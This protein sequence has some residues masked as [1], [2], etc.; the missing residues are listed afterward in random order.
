MKK[1]KNQI[2]VSLEEKEILLREL[3]H[4]TKNN[5][6]VIISMLNLQTY[7]ISDKKTLEIFKETE[8]RIR[9][10]AMVH[11]KLY[12]GK[13]LSRIDMK[14]YINDLVSLLMRS[15]PAMLGRIAF[16]LDMESVSITIDSAVPCGLIINE[17]FSNAMKHAFPGDRKGEIRVS[18]HSDEN[19]EITLFMGDDG[20]GMPDDVDIRKCN[21]LG[22]QT[23]V[24]LTEHQL[25][26]QLDFI[27][28]SGAEF[29]IRFKEPKYKER[30]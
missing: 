17:L 26:G 23:I 10:M 9:S 16:K 13:S 18:L 30:V 25:Q 21:S 28:H 29:H 14:N 11:E 22:L 12:Q 24:S 27:G 1:S 4:R 6:Q 7:G 5:M 19:G 8:N 2:K 15:Y 20:V 3:Y